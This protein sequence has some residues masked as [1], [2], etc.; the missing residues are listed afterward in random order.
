M[1][2]FQLSDIKNFKGGIDQVTTQNLIKNLVDLLLS[3]D[4]INL[5][6]GAE[7][8]S[9]VLALREDKVTPI[10]EDNSNEIL[11]WIER[12]YDSSIFTIID[13]HTHK[14]EDVIEKTANTLEYIT[15]ILLQIRENVFTQEFLKNKIQ[16]STSDF[17][18]RQLESYEN[19]IIELNDEHK[20]KLDSVTR[21]NIIQKIDKYFKEGYETNQQVDLLCGLVETIESHKFCYSL[22][23]A[24]ESEKYVSRVK[25]TKFA[26]GGRIMVSKVSADIEMA[27]SAPTVDWIQEFEAKIRGLETYLSLEFTFQKQHISKYKS[28]LN[29]SSMELLKMTKTDPKIS[30]EDEEYKLRR[31][32]DDFSNC[33]IECELVVGERKKSLTSAMTPCRGSGLR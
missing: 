12:S 11:K 15:D 32:Y 4:T 8:I 28:L 14:N 22:G 26:G 33:G 21:E 17:E 19:Y 20:E 29:V 13:D 6:D 23:W 27:G 18:K 10:S 31:L 16:S 7:T 2:I 5:H 3:Q 25:R 30:I 1:S 24:L 9:D